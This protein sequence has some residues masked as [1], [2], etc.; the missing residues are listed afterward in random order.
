LSTSSSRALPQSLPKFF[1]RH[2]D[3]EGLAA[4]DEEEE[5]FVAILFPEIGRTIMIRI[6]FSGSAIETPRFLAG[7]ACQ[8]YWDLQ[9]A[10]E[11]SRL[12]KDL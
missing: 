10:S 6:P 1:D 4:V 11:G 7:T 8:P 3:L 5:N 12:T 2:T 9:A